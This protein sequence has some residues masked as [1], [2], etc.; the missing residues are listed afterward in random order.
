MDG[1]KAGVCEDGAH[2]YILRHLWRELSLKHIY[3]FTRKNIV[4][5]LNI[6]LKALFNFIDA[7][8]KELFMQIPEFKE[9]ILN[10]KQLNKY[11]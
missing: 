4:G 1:V 3:G 7:E 11:I 9:F 5:L 2:Y 6:H 10:E 8:G